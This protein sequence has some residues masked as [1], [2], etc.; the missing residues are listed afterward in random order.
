MENY[1]GNTCLEHSN[2]FELKPTGAG[3]DPANGNQ[4]RMM[5][6]P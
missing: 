1:N 2:F 3:S 6:N 4:D 5:P